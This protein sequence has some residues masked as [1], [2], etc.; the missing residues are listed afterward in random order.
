MAAAAVAPTAARRA[1][2]A[3]PCTSWS[4]DRRPARPCAHRARGA[5]ANADLRHA[6]AQEQQ[7]LVHRA[8]P[9]LADGTAVGSLLFVNADDLAD[10]EQWAADDPY[11]AAGLFSETTIAPLMQFAMRAADDEGE[12]A[13]DFGTG[14]N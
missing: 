6:A 4:P 3:A 7:P 1:H 8:G 14:D 13:D 2:A 9:L 5:P 11:K 10:A 12:Q